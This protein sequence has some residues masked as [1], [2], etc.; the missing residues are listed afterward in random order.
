MWEAR[1]GVKPTMEIPHNSHHL[2]VALAVT[3]TTGASQG[4][5]PSPSRFLSPI[6]AHVAHTPKMVP[7][8]PAPNTQG[9][10]PKRFVAG[11]QAAG[12]VPSWCPRGVPHIFF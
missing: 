3:R 2:L 7:T 4:P 5:L 10:A 11:V 1:G 8:C 9:L 12:L 6:G